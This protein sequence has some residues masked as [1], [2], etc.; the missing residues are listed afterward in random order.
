METTAIY[1]KYNGLL[2]LQPN[3]YEFVD[4]RQWGLTVAEGSR[5]PYSL[6]WKVVRWME[7]WLSQDEA[8]KRL[9]V[10]RS[11]VHRLSNQYQTEAY[12]FRRHVPGRPQA[13]TLAGDRFIVLSA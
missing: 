2:F 6:R 11:V 9:N 8:A 7:K 3:I 5:L 4:N 1:R 12:A 10:S 13:T